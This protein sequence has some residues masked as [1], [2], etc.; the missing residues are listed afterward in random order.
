MLQWGMPSHK[1]STVPLLDYFISYIRATGTAVGMKAAAADH[2]EVD[3]STISNALT[4]LRRE[5]RLGRDVFRKWRDS[6]DS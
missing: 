1:V 6:R 3:R 5:K 4:H 2:F